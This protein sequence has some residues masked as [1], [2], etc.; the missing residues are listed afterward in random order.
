MN[1]ILKI[2]SCGF[3][4]CTFTTFGLNAAANP[5]DGDKTAAACSNESNSQ[6]VP[7][8]IED[9][10]FWM[11]IGVCLENG[12]YRRWDGKI[13]RRLDDGKLVP[14]DD[15]PKDKADDLSLK[16]EKSNN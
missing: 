8:E 16:K 2:L 15:K 14:V 7:M 9:E 4:I 10:D 6:V 11:Y 5:D 12:L 13:C 1:K 3:A